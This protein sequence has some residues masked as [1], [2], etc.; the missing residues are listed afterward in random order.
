M[1][2]KR[3]KNLEKVGTVDKEQV[4]DQ[5]QDEVQK[6]LFDEKYPLGMPRHCLCM[7]GITQTR[8]STINQRLGRNFG[9]LDF[10]LD[11][12]M[13][14][15]ATAT[16]AKKLYWLQSYFN[17]ET[18]GSFD[19]SKLENISDKSI[20]EKYRQ[21]SIA[22]QARDSTIQKKDEIIARLNKEISSLKYKLRKQ[23]NYE[24]IIK[25]SEMLKYLLKE[26]IEED[27]HGQTR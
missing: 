5:Y 27:S 26:A 18:N 2:A 15:C 17:G 19:D 23:K 21:A 3:K 6:V 12:F 8:Y 14:S 10:S 20:A 4:I 9:N 24:R 7:R 1:E 16:A 22:I 11:E 13:R 25:R